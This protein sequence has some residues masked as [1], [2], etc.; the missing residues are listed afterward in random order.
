MFKT[1]SLNTASGSFPQ[2]STKTKGEREK[3]RRKNRGKGEERERR[4]GEKRGG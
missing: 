2:A 1:P 3:E 4:G